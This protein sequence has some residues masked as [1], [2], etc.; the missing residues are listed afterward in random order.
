MTKGKRVDIIVKLTA[1]AEA[2]KTEWRVSKALQE[3]GR[4]H[5]RKPEKK[6]EKT[7]KKVLTRESGFDIITK[8]HLK[9]CAKLLEN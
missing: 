5:K 8:L 7:L 9:R 2:I 6:L 1:R 3:Q 4:K